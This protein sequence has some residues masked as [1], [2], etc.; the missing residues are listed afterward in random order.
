MSDKQITPLAVVTI[1]VLARR[2]SAQSVID[3]FRCGFDHDSVL[4][5]ETS[6]LDTLD[7][8]IPEEDAEK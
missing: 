7:Y 4:A 8:D 6:V 3:N 1:T 2:I 5:W